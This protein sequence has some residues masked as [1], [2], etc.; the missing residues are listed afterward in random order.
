M[1]L[2]YSRGE[3]RYFSLALTFVAVPYV[4]HIS[5]ALRRGLFHSTYGFDCF[6]S[7]CSA[8]LMLELTFESYN[9]LISK[10]QSSHLI[11]LKLLETLVEGC[12]SSLLQL[13]VL[14]RRAIDNDTSFVANN[15]DVIVIIS[16]CISKI[17]TSMC[18]STYTSNKDQL[19]QIMN[20]LYKGYLPDWIVSVVY[21]LFTIYH[22]K[23][24]DW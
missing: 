17:G 15:Y 24:F 21:S 10:V 16:L 12:P 4:L 14:V 23:Y 11:H 1:S 5:S 13:Y 19:D 18:L 2:Y 22:Q 6:P 7:F 3:Y 9:S 8:M 20:N